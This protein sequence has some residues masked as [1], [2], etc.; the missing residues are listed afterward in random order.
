MPK[1]KPSRDTAKQTYI[2]RTVESVAIEGPA[3]LGGCC[4]P[5][6]IQNCD[7]SFFCR[8]LGNCRLDGKDSGGG[9]LGMVGQLMDPARL[10]KGGSAENTFSNQLG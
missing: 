9:L 2:M 5:S 4:F 3:L 6:S 7:S 8:Y 10:R 1:S